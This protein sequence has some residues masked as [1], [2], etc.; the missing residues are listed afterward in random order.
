M[1]EGLAE[2]GSGSSYRVGSGCVDLGHTA[3]L[4][5]PGSQPRATPFGSRQAAL[6]ESHQWRDWS[7]YLSPS[8]Y[9]NSHEREYY[10]VRTSVGV[11]DVS[12]L[13]KYEFV[14]PDALA[15]AQRLFTRTFAKCRVDQVRYTCWCDDRGKLI[16]DGNVVRLAEDRF[17]VTAA[18]PSLRWFEDCA[19]GLDV[20]VVDRSVELAALAVQGPNSA[21]LL[22]ECLDDIDVAALKYFRGA[23]ATCGHHQLYVTRTGFTGDLGYELWMD[24]DAAPAV[25]DHLFEMGDRFRALPVGLAALD[26]VRIEAGLVLIDVDFV[27]VHAA[28]TPRLESTPFEAGLGFTVS[29][30]EGNDFVGRSAL[31]QHRSE[32][33]QWVLTGLEV[34]F[35]EL[36]AAYRARGLR[37]EIVG[38][39]P[40]RERQPLMLGDAQVGQ[41]TSQVFSPLLRSHVAIVTLEASKVRSVTSVEIELMIDSE[42]VRLPALLRKLPF[43]DPERKRLLPDLSLTS[44]RSHAG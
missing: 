11:I 2:R 3:K 7:G 31:E 18:A 21:A 13:F 38:Q 34:G 26:Q 6:T 29:F 36:D 24:A 5:R 37:P 40:C 1:A 42:R 10:A 4:L 44:P 35:A 14:G 41:V 16:Q 30:V 32:E 27:S 9:G 22:H 33:T 28:K 23:S 8:S 20:E 39:P 12:P 17:R 43:F 15:L 19:H 25:W